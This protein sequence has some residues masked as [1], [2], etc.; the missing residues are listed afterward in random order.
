MPSYIITGPDG[1]KYKVTGAD[2]QG[3]YNALKRQ[4]GGGSADVGSAGM[5]PD[6]GASIPDISL[7]AAP[8]GDASQWSSAKEGM[9][10]LTMGGQS[11]L[12]A[13][14]GA[15]VR[16]AFDV[17]RGNGWTWGDNYD[18]ILQEQR[19]NQAAYNEE[20]PI[21]TGLGRAGGIM[22]G[23]AR[24]PAWAG[25]AKAPGWARGLLGASATGSG[26][27]FIGG[28][29]EDAS[30]IEDRTINALKGTGAG[31]LIGFGGYGA[32]KVVAKG[33]E[34]VSKAFSTVNAPPLN[35]AEQEVF[36][37]INKAGGPAAVQQK[38]AELGPDAALA[39]VLGFAGTATTR[40]AAN[41]SPE[42]RQILT[43][44][45]EGRKAGQN[46]RLATDVEIASGLPVGNIKNVDALKKEAY[47]KVRP[48]INKAYTSA[49]KAGAEV[50]L[51]EFDNIITTPIGRTA[52]QQA[53]DNV[54]SRAARD[55][56]AGGNLAVLDETKRILDGWAKKGFR[57]GDPMASEYASAAE[58]LRTRL[59]D[60]LAGDEYA[61]ARALRQD[62]Y[63]GDEAFDL[64]AKLAGSRVGLGLP[65]AVGKVKPQHK[66]KV[67]QAYGATKVEDLLNRNATEGAYADMIRP[68]GRAA[69]QAALGQN[70][71]IIQKA[72]GRERQ[73]NITNR[74]LVG[75]S[76]TARQLAEMAGWGLG[77]AT[78]SQLMGN[79]IWT[80][81]ITGLL[82]A[83]GR[84]SL[85]TITQKLVTERQ[86]LVAPFL[87]EIL[88]KAQL[89]L[90]RPIPPGF[91]EKFVTGGDQKL[92]RT[93]QLMWIDAIQKNSP[94]TNPAQ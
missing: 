60:L 29:L 74:E 6:I 9:D 48:T 76:T 15:L 37:L 2:P 23:V 7:Q 41:I 49:R 14:G 26:Y 59:D 92:A 84:R 55:P 93:L 52:F 50:D 56:S 94:Q 68:Q 16:S 70:D 78:I 39:D 43:D 28:A 51:T 38:L 88:T 58:A 18:K 62:A 80:T 42:A 64:G 47:D 21:G 10:T 71:S 69:S 91:L 73:F 4:L 17:A 19:D 86:R 90:N 65:Q 13:A 32:G 46:T 66:Q 83:V 75:N 87:A 57:D 12:N 27:G 82:G 25:P 30:S 20:N 8:V 31:A 5:A 40:R 81:G 24:G 3:A 63:Q 34:K 85:P 61:V 44:F 45:V 22:I 53:L 54:T 79:D 11:K 67:A 33:A 77:T 72:I 89:P 1:K 36:D 35:K